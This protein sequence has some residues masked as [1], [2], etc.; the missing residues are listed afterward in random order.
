MKILLLLFFTAILW[1]STPIIEKIGLAKTE[2]ITG[3]TIRS[4]AVC[5]AL[6]L[7]LAFSGKLKTAFTA[8]AK[9]III[10]SISGIL[11]GLVGM[12]T[13]FKALKAG[14]TSEVVPIAAIYP[15]VTAIL[16]VLI[17][18]EQITPLR[19]MGTILIVAGVWLVQI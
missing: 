13:Y 15:L 11:A 7:Y 12:I 6:L 8:D 9:T 2:P 14:A 18:G 10:F 1:G 4:V 3:I 16:S 17:L 19:I 5:I